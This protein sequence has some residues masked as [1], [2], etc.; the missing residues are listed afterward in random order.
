METIN[1]YTIAQHYACAVINEDW[2]GLDDQEAK[3]LSDWLDSLR[4]GYLVIIDDSEKEF[5]RCDVSGLRA[6]TI[7][8]ALMQ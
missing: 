8:I 5:A 3:E 7:D 2:T 4:E 1:T 6:S